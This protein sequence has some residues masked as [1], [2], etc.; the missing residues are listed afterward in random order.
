MAPSTEPTF[1]DRLGVRPEAPMDDLRAAY[2]RRARELHPDVARRTGVDAHLAMA[3]LNR[4]W[5]TLSD[6]ERRRAYDR[7]LRA[8]P[9]ADAGRASSTATRSARP[10]GPGADPAASSPTWRRE[11]WLTGVGVQMRRILDQAA[12][13]S[14]QTLLVRHRGRART[15]YEA[16]IDPI[17]NHVV[18]DVGDRVRTARVAGAAP[19]DLAL[20]GSLVG[21]RSFANRLESQA[22]RTGA[23]APAVLIAAEMVDRM[24]DVLAHEL[25]HDLVAALGG[26]PHVLRRVTP[27]RN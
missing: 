1:Y 25:P 14:V 8:V 21:L 26:N 2:R 23:P 27:R 11:Q 9:S 17:V 15:T 22:Q 16:A 13:S 18:S 5:Q 4:A 19:L 3:E 24:F 20:V 7:S 10:S 12:R 6:P